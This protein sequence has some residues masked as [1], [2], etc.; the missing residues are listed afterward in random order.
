MKTDFQEEIYT[1][2]LDRNSKLYKEK[3]ELAEKLA[4]EILSV[5]SS[6]VHVQEERG[7]KTEKD[8][9]DEEDK[10]GAVVRNHHPEINRYI[11]PAL[12]NVK[13]QKA[14]RI[15]ENSTAVPVRRKFSIQSNSSASVK[16]DAET[17]LIKVAE[18][19]KEFSAQEKVILEQKKQALAKKE[20]LVK[21]EE[22]KQ[23]SKNFKIPERLRKEEETSSK[24]ESN[25]WSYGD[26]TVNQTKEGIKPPNPVVKTEMV[27]TPVKKDEKKSSKLSAFASSFTP[28]VNAAPFVPVSSILI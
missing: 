7:Q 1:T 27:E 23:F 13:N 16:I 24:K 12:R 2:K 19:F 28:N 4:N 11:P 21:I 10:Y 6:N 3:E 8:D 14:E 18:D 15:P 26:S 17:T 22:M 9:M 25:S 5:S 20:R